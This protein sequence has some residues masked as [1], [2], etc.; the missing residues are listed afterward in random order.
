MEKLCLFCVHWRFY[1]GSEYY[2]EETPGSSA[3]MD[4][5]KKHYKTF[6]IIDLYD[7]RAFR[8]HIKQAETCPDYE[9]VKV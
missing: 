8:I 3:E 4:C 9:Q 5:A 6:N 2:S 7:E 1:G